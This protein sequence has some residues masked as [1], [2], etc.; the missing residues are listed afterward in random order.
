MTEVNVVFAADNNYVLPTL[1]AITSLLENKKPD[2]FYRIFI[3]ENKIAGNNKAKFLWP[4]FQGQY[5]VRFMAVDLEELEKNKAYEAWTGVTTDAKFFI[6]DL[7]TDYDQCIY[8]DGDTLVLDDLTGLFRTDL[9]NACLG[10]IKSP[11]TNYNVAAG[12]HPVLARDPYFLKCFNAGVFV[13]NLKKLR[14]LGGGKRFS[15]D[16]LSTIKNLP[17]GTPV[18][19]M[20][21][22]NKLLVDTYV[23][24][25]LKYNFYVNNILNFFDIRHY[26]PFCFDRDAIT[27]AF[28]APVIVH[29]TVPEKPWKY[30]DAEKAY[31]PPYKKY[32]RLWDS[33]YKKSPLGTEKLTRKHL[34]LFYGFWMAAKPVLKQSPALRALKRVLTRTK[35]GAPVSALFD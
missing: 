31:A 6:C 34:P 25:P 9:K 15:A 20:D 17:A 19:E 3:L 32:R 13:M 2:T 21:I 18:T 29:F 33:Y 5:E 11:G 1:V 24:L 7:L 14:D 4:R 28:T 30:A 16:M 27:E 26:L 10:V 12:K 23:Y 35:K 22:L 8:M